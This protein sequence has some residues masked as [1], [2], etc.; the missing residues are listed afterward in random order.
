[1]LSPKQVFCTT[2]SKANNRPEGEMGR[3]ESWKTERRAAKHDIQGMISVATAHATSQQFQLPALHL[4]K[5]G[6]V[7]IQSWT[8]E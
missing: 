5:T 2:L 8:E 6:P 7:N 4:R 1:M 3:M